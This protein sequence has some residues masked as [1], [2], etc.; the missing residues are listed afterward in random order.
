MFSRVG[1][2]LVSLVFLQFEKISGK[3]FREIFIF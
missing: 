2:I 3:V 1:G